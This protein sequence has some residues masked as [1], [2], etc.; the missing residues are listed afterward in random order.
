MI[1][2]LNSLRISKGLP[3]M[4]FINPF[5]YQANAFGA[6]KGLPFFCRG[7][8]FPPTFCANPFLYQANA[9]GAHKGLPFCRSFRFLLPIFVIDSLFC[10]SFRFLLPIFVSPTFPAYFLFVPDQRFWCLQKVC[11]FVGVLASFPLNEVHFS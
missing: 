5:L 10:R 8:R 9:F 2:M 11:L 6:Y 4:G 1:S 3:T 7:F